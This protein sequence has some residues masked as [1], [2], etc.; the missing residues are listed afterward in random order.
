MRKTVASVIIVLIVLLAIILGWKPINSLYFQAPED[1]FIDYPNAFEIHA[2]SITEP[3]VIETEKSKSVMYEGCKVTVGNVRADEGGIFITLNFENVYHYNL[4][5]ILWYYN[6]YDNATDN[7]AEGTV[8][9]LCD[10]V[11]YECKKRASGYRELIYY[12]EFPYSE[13][14]EFDIEM[15][16]FIFTTYKRV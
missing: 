14:A 15:N 6:A 16:N 2:I 11:R 1:M 4:G 13:N 7:L 8:A 3:L 9:L 12:C 10:G 5:K